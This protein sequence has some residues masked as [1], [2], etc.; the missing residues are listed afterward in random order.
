MY[1]VSDVMELEVCWAPRVLVE[2]LDAA[3]KDCCQQQRKASFVESVAAVH[4]LLLLLLLAVLVYSFAGVLVKLAVWSTRELVMLSRAGFIGD[5]SRGEQVYTTRRAT[6][7][8]LTRT[9]SE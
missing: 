7:A 8:R 1:S 2:L 6:R 9:P 3:S 5:N 4:D